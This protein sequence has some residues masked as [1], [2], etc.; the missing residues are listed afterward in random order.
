MNKQH[1]ITGSS[2]GQLLVQI[3]NA[4]RCHD[5]RI[6]GEN[7]SLILTYTS[8]F[9]R[10][11]SNLLTAERMRPS[12]FTYQRM[13]ADFF[14]PEHWPLFMEFVRSVVCGEWDDDELA[15]EERDMASS[16]SN[17]NVREMQAV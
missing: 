14:S 11:R 17:A 10:I 4:C 1:S 2:P 12:H 7:A 5:A 9:S 15:D 13:G 8:S 16:S 3:K 6:A